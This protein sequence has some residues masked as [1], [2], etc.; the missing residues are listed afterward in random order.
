MWFILEIDELSYFYIVTL[1]NKRRQNYMASSSFHS[2][3][4]S[5]FNDVSERS[6]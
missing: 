6:R 3:Y 4:Y 2:T 5:V 1:V